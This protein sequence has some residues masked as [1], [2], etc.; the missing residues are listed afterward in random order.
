M[1]KKCLNKLK[2]TEVDRRNLWFT[3]NDTHQ[4]GWNIKIHFFLEVYTILVYSVNL[5]WKEVSLAGGTSVSCL[6]CHANHECSQHKNMQKKFVPKAHFKN[7]GV[8][9]KNYA[10]RGNKVQKAISSFK[11]KV[12]A[13]RSLTLLSFERAALVEYACHIWSLY[14]SRFKSYSEGFWQQTDIYTN[15]QTDR[16]DSNNM[17]P[18]YRSGG[19]ILK[20]QRIDFDKGG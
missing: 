1:S 12:K 4:V 8:F 6:W 5:G 13:T 15:K 9:V 3:S 18:I 16:Q 19:I 14:L 10:P 7:Q 2:P 17:P 20:P 11:V